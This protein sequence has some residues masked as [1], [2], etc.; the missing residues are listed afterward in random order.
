MAKALRFAPIFPVRDL[1]VALAHYRALGFATRPYRD[2]GYG[3]A[4]LDD[5]EIHFS[6]VPPDEET[7][8]ASAYLFVDDADALAEAWAATGADVQTPADMEWKQHEGAMIDPDGN[9]IRFGS[10]T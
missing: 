1:T 9:V 4:A 7:T 3:F 5:C 8:P 2:G 6:V 10:T